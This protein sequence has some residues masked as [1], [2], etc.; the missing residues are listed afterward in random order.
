MIICTIIIIIN[1][2]NNASLTSPCTLALKFKSIYLLSQI[3]VNLNKHHQ[4]IC[5]R[6]CH[7][8]RFNLNN[9]CQAKALLS[10]NYYFLQGNIPFGS[11][12]LYCF[13]CFFD[14]YVSI[15][16][17]HSSFLL[18][19]YGPFD[20]H[21]KGLIW[22]DPRYFTSVSLVLTSLL[23]SSPVSSCICD[24]LIW[25]TSAQHLKVLKPNL[26]FCSSG[27]N[28]CSS[29][30]S[31]SSSRNYHFECSHSTQKAESYPLLQLILKSCTFS[32]FY[33]S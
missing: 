32:S 5:L 22:W 14:H 10:L 21:L 19:I 25:V 20:S 12:L 24:M 4:A 27:K 11:I 2:N 6:K 8:C 33:N 9:S 30:V 7:L 17:A 31:C 23:C 13:S 28:L 29:C 3:S 26:T 18:P 15:S 1:S 16:L